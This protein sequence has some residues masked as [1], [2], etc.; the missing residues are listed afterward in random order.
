MST[1]TLF[2]LTGAPAVLWNQ[3][4]N[5]PPGSYRSQVLPAQLMGRYDAR[6]AVASTSPFAAAGDPS[7][8]VI[9][10]LF[11]AAQRSA[12]SAMCR[13]CRSGRIRAAT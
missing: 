11:V 10:A 5:L 4:F 7:A 3:Q 1:D 8:S 6:V 12:G 2:G 13:G 9:N